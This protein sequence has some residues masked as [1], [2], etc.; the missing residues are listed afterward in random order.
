LKD[1]KQ[2]GREAE[3]KEEYRKNG[4]KLE[5]RKKRTDRDRMEGR[6]KE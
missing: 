1:E 4:I 5:K 2:K 3:K 6:Q